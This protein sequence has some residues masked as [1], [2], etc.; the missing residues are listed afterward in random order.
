MERDENTER[1]R[2]EMAAD[3]RVIVIAHEAD[4]FSVV[5]MLGC[6]P[7]R[8]H[9]NPYVPRGEAFGVRV[10]APWYT[11]RSHELGR[12]VGICADAPWCARAFLRASS[13][14]ASRWHRTTAAQWM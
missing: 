8:V 11:R 4:F 3:D 5:G 13:K 6:D 2:R 7:D 14:A 12:F 1:L 10:E 9:C